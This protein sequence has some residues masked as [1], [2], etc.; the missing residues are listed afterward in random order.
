[1]DNS[2]DTQT[3]RSNKNILFTFIFIYLLF[4]TSRA[5]FTP[6]VT[7]YLQEK[8]FATEKIGFITG[9]NSLV[10]IIAQPFWGI[11]TD[12]LRSSKYTLVICLMLQAA[13]S[14]ALV[15]CNTFLTVAACFC[16][17][18]FFSSPEGPLLDTWCLSN[19]KKIGRNN[20]VGRMKFAGCFGYALVSILSGYVITSYD[21]AKILP[22]F[23]VILFCIGSFLLLVRI[24]SRTEKKQPAGKTE[25][26]KI[27]KDS[28]FLLFLVIIF[29]MQIPHRAAY[30]FYPVLISSLGGD[31]AFV[32]YTSAVMFVSEGI[33]MFCSQ[34][35]LSR[36]RAVDI[37]MLSG[38]FFTIWQILYVIV[39][40]PWQ[41]AAIAILDGPSYA[42][43][44]I[45]ILY[46]LDEIAPVDM[47][48]TYQT[49]TYAVYFGLSGIAGNSMGG[50]M[51]EKYGFKN[52]YVIGAIII[53]VSILCLYVTSKSRTRKEV[54]V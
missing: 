18:G 15:H 39:G 30:T 2:R 52:M 26:K 6:Y 7:V 22:V 21:T 12:K 34:K 4:M 54:V 3:Q 11:I 51:I 47:K 5:I 24:D 8:G 35:L 44:T 53:V 48:A 33:I 43:F 10:L 13:F 14:L 25:F 16:M 17:Y 45:G 9:A 29:L 41:V 46:Y 49:V 36:F 42:L 28:R 31:K 1:M 27:L 38:V 37:V 50:W 23:S 20:A 40:Q 19:L 32:G